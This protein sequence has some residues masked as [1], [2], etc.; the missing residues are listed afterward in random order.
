MRSA[1][2]YWWLEVVSRQIRIE[3]HLASRV[4]LEPD[5]GIC[6]YELRLCREDVHV[7]GIMIRYMVLES[8][9]DEAVGQKVRQA[10]TS[11]M[12]NGLDA[13]LYMCTRKAAWRPQ[14]VYSVDVVG[15]SHR[16]S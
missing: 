13:G 10:Q 11:C 16:G 12:K 2:V 3:R 15:R 5:N 1:F 7:L 8:V 9:P 4:T 6:C 14:A